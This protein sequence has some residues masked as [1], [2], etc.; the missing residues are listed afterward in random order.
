MVRAG[1]EWDV[2]S[3]LGGLVGVIVQWGNGVWR[4]VKICSGMI[5]KGFVDTGSDCFVGRV[6]L[7]ELFCVRA[8][9]CDGKRLSPP[10]LNHLLEAR[11]SDE[12]PKRRNYISRVANR[13]HLGYA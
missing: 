5:S 9:I 8:V 2:R 1:I 12:N 10:L 3:G 13:R 6:N 7:E 11:I 4:V